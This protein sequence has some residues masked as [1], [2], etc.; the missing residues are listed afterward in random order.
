MGP[1]AG[2]RVWLT[3]FWVFG[4]GDFGHPQCVRSG[5]M[6]FMVSVL[7]KFWVSGFRDFDSASRASW[8]ASSAAIPRCLRCA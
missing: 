8:G 4:Q 6:T 5:H 3:G 7:A 2:S 1:G